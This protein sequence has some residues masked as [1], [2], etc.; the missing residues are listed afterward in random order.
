MAVKRIETKSG[1]VCEIDEAVVNDMEV[2]DLIVEIEKGNVL[3]Y[4]AL[5]DKLLG[6]ELKQKL[7]DHVRVDGRVPYVAVDAEISDI[8]SGIG[9][10]KN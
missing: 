10:G 8:F 3:K 5:L 9:G 6:T 2:L 7:Y 4:P 1:F